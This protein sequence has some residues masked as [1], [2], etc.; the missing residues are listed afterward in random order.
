MPAET[1]TPAI[2]SPVLIV[3]VGL[4][5]LALAIRLKRARVDDFVLLEAGDELGGTWRD[6]HYPGLVCD[7]ESCLYSYSFE[8]TPRWTRRFAPQRE[9]LEYLK[10]CAEKHDIQRHIRFNS[11]VAAARFD[12]RTSTWEVMTTDHRRFRARVLVSA[13]GGLVQPNT[14]DI[15]GLERFEGPLFH[16]ARFRHDVPLRGKTVAVIGTG[17]S[18]A[19]VIPAIAPIVRKLHVFQRTPPWVLPKPDRAIPSWKR[20][21]ARVVSLLQRAERCALYWRK[22][23]FVGTGFLLVQRLLKPLEASARKHLEQRVPNAALRA[24]LTPKYAIGCKR[25]VLSNDYLPALLRTN[26][27]LVTDRITEIRAGSIITDDGSERAVDVIIAATG[28]DWTDGSVSFD[29]TGPGGRNLRDVWRDGAEAYLG[30]AIAGFPNLFLLLGPNTWVGHTSMVLMIEAQARYIQRAIETMRA[31]NLAR[32]EVRSDVQAA[33]NRRVQGRF[34]HTLWATERDSWCR[35]K[36]GKNTA[37]WPGYTFEYRWRT[38]RFD[39]AAYDVVVDD[40]PAGQSWWERGS[41][42]E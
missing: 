13:C 12:E 21:R 40:A 26:V 4:S 18:A 34:R 27:E 11:R 28:F 14:P 20:S 9:I 39:A 36:P 8:P 37:R 32:V 17:A 16:T 22:E 42:V 1:T 31:R 38:R 30:T 10:V 5:G 29:V 35:K 2:T 7:I 24:R 15:P 6:N 23:L 41:V 3:G 19:Q 33:Y 25:V